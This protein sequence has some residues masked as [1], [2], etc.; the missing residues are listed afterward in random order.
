MVGQAPGLHTHFRHR[1][2]EP[3]VPGMACP[4]YRLDNGKVHNPLAHADICAPLRS[5]SE[6][7]GLLSTCPGRG[8]SLAFNSPFLV[9]LPIPQLRHH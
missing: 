3:L 2:G 7:A 5:C 9:K 1:S 6:P 4:V 8:R